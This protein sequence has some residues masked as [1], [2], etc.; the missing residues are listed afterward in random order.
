M[1]NSH[2]NTLGVSVNELFQEQDHPI[3]DTRPKEE[4]IV[5]LLCF[6]V[7]PNSREGG[8][9]R[10][11][12][13]NFTL[14]FPKFHSDFCRAEFVQSHTTLEGQNSREEASSTSHEET[15]SNEEM[16]PKH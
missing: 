4:W 14:F 11:E 13:Q 6:F 15:N 5:T 9:K 3:E 12:K 8:R 1:N 2:N 16:T 10:K 7:L